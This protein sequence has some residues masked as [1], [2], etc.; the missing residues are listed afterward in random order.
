MSEYAQGHPH[1]TQEL[2]YF[3]WSL[4]EAEKAPATPALVDRALNRVV[5]AEDA[6]HTTLWDSLP[7]R[8]RLVLTALITSG[9]EAVYSEE[10]RRRHRLGAASSVQKS[11]E[12]LMAR[13]L[14]ERMPE[15][16]YR[17]A[18]TFLRAWVSRGASTGAGP[19]RRLL[20]K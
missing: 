14:V 2:C 13:D 18:D 16:T 5:D 7:A 11:L 1:D 4:A 12:L 9:G 3:T 8:Q 20:D 19:Y 17:V 10:Y 15:G 6:R